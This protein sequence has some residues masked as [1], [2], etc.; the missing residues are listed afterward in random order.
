MTART[1][2]S[3]VSVC[4][5]CFLSS[6]VAAAPPTNPPASVPTPK[7]PDLLLTDR[8][9]AP[10]DTVMPLS[11]WSAI[12]RAASSRFR[13]TREQITDEGKPKVLLRQLSRPSPPQGQPPGRMISTDDN[14]EAQDTLDATIRSY[15]RP[16]STRTV[17]LV[18]VSSDLG[19]IEEVSV[20][21]PSG[22]PRFD[23]EAI[24]CLRDAFAAYPPKEDRRPMM[25]RWRV[26][27]G[28]GVTL[29]K[30]LQP[31]TPRA[32]NAK[33]PTR[34]IPL[35]VPVWGTFDESRGT[36]NTQHA[37]ADK[38]ETQIELL[39]QRPK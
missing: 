37:F 17:E 16:A 28:Y 12:R 20:V 31:L 35:L 13:P 39:E 5:G 32:A 1:L 33:V 8:R 21:M 4:F 15:E 18:V 11:D 6:I 19:Q 29:P 30:A 36:S 27:A 14:V 3:C 26:R 7:Y 25:S 2:S 22:S 23:E 10:A 38:I 9:L 34:G 24:T